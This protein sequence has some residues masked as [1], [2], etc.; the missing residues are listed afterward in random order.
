MRSRVF[1]IFVFLSILLSVADAQ[2]TLQNKIETI[3]KDDF[4]SSSHIGVSVRDV[5]NNAVLADVNKDKR[6]VPASSLKLITTLISLEL[7]GEDYVYKTTIT[8]DGY[9]DDF[10]ILKGNLYIEGSGDPSFGSD[11]IP[12]VPD[13]KAQLEIIL[14]DI[15]KYGI[16]CIEG[17][18][19]SDESVFNSFSVA[20]TWQWN[21]LG[22][23]YAAGAWGLN[24]NENLYNVY[25]NSNKPIGSPS[26]I[27]YYEPRI[28][29]LKL[30][31]EVTID[32]AHTGD[33]VYI[34]GGPYH[35]GK[36]AIGTV[37]QGKTLFKV[38]GSIPDPPLF[39]A[40][41]LLSFLEKND[42]GGLNYKTLY[43]TTNSKASRKKIV[44]YTSPPLKLLVKYANDYSINI[45]CE[46]FLKTLGA[47]KDG[48]GSGANG[49]EVIEQ[50][51]KSNKIS[52][53][54]CVMA[55]G[56]GLSNRNLLSPDVLTTFLTLIGSKTKFDSLYEVIPPAGIR[57]TVKSLF[58]GSS[59]QG[60]FLVKTGSM[61]RVLTYSGY[62]QAI[63]GKFV[64]FSVFLN[65]SDFPK[66]RDN[67]LKLAKIL[68]SI[69]KYS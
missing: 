37:P 16:Q 45:Y 54:N 61:D 7:L 8:H 19:I 56:S 69:Y 50:Y 9:I 5:S 66:P 28:P 1:F 57:G 21:D 44:Q 49:I 20:P 10:G 36:R 68:E 11:R 30:D 35:Y 27:A 14:K 25:F 53:E 39:F 42:M 26:P 64:A 3:L 2:P 38:K 63:S 22:N 15:K 18:I 43:R 32:S 17:D 60:K 4:Y 51:L 59:L 29:N 47:E 58:G 24:V 23:Y 33:N 67:K 41:T 12:G 31:N 34:F 40:Y 13:L 55:D 48:M 62:C 65:H 46:S 6:L 52:L